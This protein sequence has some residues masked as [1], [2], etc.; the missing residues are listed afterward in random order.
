MIILAKRMIILM[1]YFR[2]V[3]LGPSFHCSHVLLA[4]VI[5][6]AQKDK[7]VVGSRPQPERRKG[8]LKSS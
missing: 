8:I 1:D 4:V 7:K 2:L 3:L 5:S 6:R